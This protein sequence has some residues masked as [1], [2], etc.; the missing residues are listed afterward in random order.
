MRPPSSL[1]LL[2]LIAMPLYR[3]E[4]AYPQYNNL[5]RKEDQRE[6]IYRIHN[7]NHSRLLGETICLEERGLNPAASAALFCSSVHRLIQ[8]YS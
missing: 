4:H 3:E 8:L 6:P 1:F 7:F 2:I 5:Q